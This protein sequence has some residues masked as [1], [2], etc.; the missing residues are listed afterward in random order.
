MSSPADV[1]RHFCALMAQR[2]AEAL[3]P[4]LAEGAV[5]QNVGMPAFSGPDA[6]VENMA[7]QFAMFPDAYAFEIVNLASEGSVVLTE[8][9][10]YIQTPDGRKPAIPVMGTFVV[11]GDGRI[12]RWTD[13]FD[14][15][16]TIKL[17]QGEDISALVPATA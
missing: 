7:A 15:N 12:T 17:L 10:D 3:R 5:Y 4:L 1:V 6:I 11:D 13:Y 8:R 16:L 2:D 14:L 9:L